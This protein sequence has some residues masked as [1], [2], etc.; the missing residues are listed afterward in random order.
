[1]T[2]QSL[3]AINKEIKSSSS[4]TLISMAIN[5][6]AQHFK[7]FQRHRQFQ[8]FCSE[9]FE[10]I[11]DKTAFKNRVLESKVPIRHNPNE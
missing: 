10:G 3:S 2:I 7:Y 5:Y 1:M 9:V 8:V 4:S 11:L 6:N